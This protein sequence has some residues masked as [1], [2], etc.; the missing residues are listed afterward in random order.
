MMPLLVVYSRTT[1]EPLDLFLTTRRE[2]LP[3]QSEIVVDDPFIFAICDASEAGDYELYK[4]TKAFKDELTFWI[5]QGRSFYPIHYKKDLGVVQNSPE[6][7]VDPFI[8]LLDE[9]INKAKEGGVR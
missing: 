2:V 4:W 6:H 7:V 1:K 5:L 8:A 9:A 3:I